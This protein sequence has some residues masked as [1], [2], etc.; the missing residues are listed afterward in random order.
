MIKTNLLNAFEFLIWYFCYCLSWYTKL[1]ISV[2]LLIESGLSC[3]QTA[4]E[5]QPHLC[6]QTA[7]STKFIL[8]DLLDFLFLSERARMWRILAQCVPCISLRAFHLVHNNDNCFKSF[9]SLGFWLIASCH[10]QCHFCRLPCR[11][12]FPSIEMWSRRY[13]PFQ[14]CYVLSLV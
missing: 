7:W 5:Y 8:I 3:P 4:V 12:L 6:N 10:F 11:L 2:S 1:V 9:G 14:F 13:Y